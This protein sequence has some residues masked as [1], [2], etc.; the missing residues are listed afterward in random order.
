MIKPCD[1]HIGN[2]RVTADHSDDLHRDIHAKYLRA[3]P[4]ARFVQPTTA[5]TWWCTAQ[6]PDQVYWRSLALHETAHAIL[7]VLVGQELLGL[8]LVQDRNILVPGGAMIQ[9]SVNAQLAAVGILGGPHAQARWLA[10]QGYTHPELKRCVIRLGGHSDARQVKAAKAEG[11]LIDRRRAVKDALRV[12][13]RRRT[14]AAHLEI[15]E[16]LLADGA[17]PP[18]AVSAALERHGVRKPKGVWIPSA[19]DFARHK[20]RLAARR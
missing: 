14:A 4:E 6:L 8:T 19:E 9:G 7:G 20:E 15:T 16:R 18:A 13:G 5:E 3:H 17:V 11:L 12:L 1:E 2:P 10:E